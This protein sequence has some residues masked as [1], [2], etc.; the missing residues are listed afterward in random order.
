MMKEG[1]SSK[2]KYTF[3]SDVLQVFPEQVFLGQCQLPK[4]RQEPRQHR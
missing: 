4:T 2:P 1:N 3:Q